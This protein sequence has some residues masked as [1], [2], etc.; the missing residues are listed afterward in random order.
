MSSLDGEISVL[1]EEDQTRLGGFAHPLPH[2]SVGRLVLLAEIPRRP[3]GGV[4]VCAAP[5]AVPGGSAGRHDEKGGDGRNRDGRHP[6]RRRIHS[7]LGTEFMPRLDEGSILV[8]TRKLPS[9]SLEES[10][11]I[12]T[13]VERSCSPS[14][15]KCRRSLPR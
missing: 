8:E 13:R 5:G 3:P 1:P 4:L 6:D 2:R 7:F 12:S 10:V 9:V 11:E 15:T 14:S